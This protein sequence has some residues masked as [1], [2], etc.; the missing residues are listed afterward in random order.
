MYG[1]C[2]LS[3]VPVR[4]EP[5]D[6]SEM[7]SQLLLGEHFTILEV[8]PK[9]VKIQNAWDN[10]VGWISNKQYDTL[11]AAQFEELNVAHPAM[12]A[13]IAHVITHQFTKETMAVVMGSV[14]P[15]YAKHAFFLAKEAYKY[16]GTI[17]A[18]A[19]KNSRH[20]IVEAAYLYLNSPYLWG[21]K[22]PFGI[23]C[24]GF[25]QMV[26][27]LCGLK[28][29]RDASEQAQMGTPLSFIEEALPG[30]LA[31]FDNEEG[32]I[33]HVGIILK[34]NN[35][36]HASGAV[37]IDKLDHQG[38]YNETTKTYSHNLRVIKNIIAD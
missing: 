18:T 26:Y 27:K 36:I 29:L 17:Q 22:S 14:L 20:A 25:T 23:D 34:N 5:S 30:D 4:A 12:V 10:Y 2:N 16:E 3:I 38:I 32:K 11:T 1:I 33:I 8:G 6:R 19:I 24:S 21:G 31:F 15:H 35:I 7:V 13:D 9:W 28:I 37:R